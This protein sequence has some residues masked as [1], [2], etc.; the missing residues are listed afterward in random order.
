MTNIC[1]TQKFLTQVYF[2]GKGRMP[3]S[4][5]N[6]LSSHPSSNQPSISELESAE[7]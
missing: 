7:A 3:S 1:R 4:V 2:G 5:L 6:V